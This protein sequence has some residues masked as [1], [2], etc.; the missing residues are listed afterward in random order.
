MPFSA[1]VCIPTIVY[2]M[3]FILR[4]SYNNKSTYAI[5]TQTA[6]NARKISKSLS[7]DERTFNFLDKMLTDAIF[8]KRVLGT[9]TTF[10]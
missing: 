1:K 6:N 9:V 10:K 3:L 8:R 4:A 5:N 2:L 7:W